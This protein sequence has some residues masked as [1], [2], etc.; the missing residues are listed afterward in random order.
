MHIIYNLKFFRKKKAEDISFIL[1]SA[2]P[3]I[4][5][6]RQVR[7]TLGKARY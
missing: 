6:L 5:L 3:G 1:L 4:K 7:L 2:K